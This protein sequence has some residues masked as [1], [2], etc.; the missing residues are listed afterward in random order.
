M[1][2]G[3]DYNESLVG[4]MVTIIILDNGIFINRVVSYTDSR[5]YACMFAYCG[6]D[7]V[8]ALPGSGTTYA[9]A[10]HK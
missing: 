8:I 6:M 4:E 1:T 7:L 5:G 10:Y 2:I 9:S 3:N